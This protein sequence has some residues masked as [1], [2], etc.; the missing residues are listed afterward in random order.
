MGEKAASPIN[1]NH[2]IAAGPDIVIQDG[3]R[4]HGQPQDTAAPRDRRRAYVDPSR[5]KQLHSMLPTICQTSP[6]TIL[7][8][9]ERSALQRM[10]K[11]MLPT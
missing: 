4:I 9:S 3:F 10:V 6:M 8:N 1:K 5:V 2:S 7:H 11:V